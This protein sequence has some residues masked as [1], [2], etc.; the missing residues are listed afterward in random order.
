ME[1]LFSQ[2][3]VFENNLYLLPSS[4][5]TYAKCSKILNSFLFLISNKMLAIKAGIHKVLV[6]IANNRLLHRMRSDL[7]VHCL[8]RQATSVLKF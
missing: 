6:R 3:R 2:K 4:F 8:S 7:G 5:M 1:D